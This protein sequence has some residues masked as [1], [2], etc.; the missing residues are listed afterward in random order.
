V[1]IKET[2]HSNCFETGEKSGRFCAEVPFV[3]AWQQPPGVE[4]LAVFARGRAEQS[5]RARGEC[6]F[7]QIFEAEWKRGG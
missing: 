3:I 1:R 6:V 2:G 4:K 5:E 7:S